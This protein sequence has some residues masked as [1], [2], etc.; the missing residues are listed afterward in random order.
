LQIK[1]EEN[2]SNTFVGSV[3]WMSPE[4]MPHAAMAGA[5]VNGNTDVYALGVV[6]WQMIHHCQFP[7]GEYQEEIQVRQLI[8]VWKE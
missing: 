3:R 4:R 2:N 1:D 6:I 8:E 7:F 5:V